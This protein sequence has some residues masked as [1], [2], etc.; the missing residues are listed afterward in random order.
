MSNKIE[1]CIYKF[2]NKNNEVIYV[3]KAKKLRDRLSAHCHLSSEQYKEVE[4]VKYTRF[5]DYN[6]LDFVE[7]YYIQKYKPKYNKT[8]NKSKEIYII[9]KL[10]R[11]RWKYFNEIDFE[12]KSKYK[13]L[14]EEREARELEYWNKKVNKIS[15][16]YFIGGI[17]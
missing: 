10:D 15:A 4:N 8:F 17:K 3:G 6:V 11:K 7:C 13:K 16:S 2:L 14:D 12:K 9:D 5:N 1:N